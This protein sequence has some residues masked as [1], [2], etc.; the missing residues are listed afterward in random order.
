MEGGV[1]NYAQSDRGNRATGTASGGKEWKKMK[2]AKTWLKYMAAVLI[3]VVTAMP[4]AAYTETV[5]GVEWTF[6][7]EDGEATLTGTSPMT[8]AVAIPGTLGEVPVTAIQSSAFWGREEVTSVSIPASVKL[9]W[10]GVFA[11]CGSLE[12]IEVAADNPEFATENGVLYSKAKVELVSCPRKTAGA[13]AVPAGVTNIIPYAFGYCGELTSVSIGGGVAVIMDYAFYGCGNLTSVSMEDGLKK[14]GPR[15]FAWCTNLMSV[16]IPASVAEIGSG[17]FSGCGKLEGIE[18]AAANGAYASEDGVL[19]DKAKEELCGFPGGKLGAYVLPD[20]VKTIR[21]GA[22]AMCAGL[23]A[24]TLGNGVASIG[25]YAFEGCAGLS[26]LTLPDSVASVGKEAFSGCSGLQT[27]RVPEAWEGTDKLAKAGVPETCAVVYGAEEPGWYVD[28]AVAASGDGTSRATAFKTLAE[29]LS[30]AA[31]GDTVWVAPGTY[32]GSTLDEALWS[33]HGAV[34]GTGKAS[35]TVIQDLSS[36]LKFTTLADVTISDGRSVLMGG[37]EWGKID[38]IIERCI[39]RGCRVENHTDYPVAWAKEIRDS[40]FV[41][42]E[43]VDTATP[44]IQAGLIVSSTLVDNQ[45]PYGLMDGYMDEE[46]DDFVTCMALNCILWNNMATQAGDLG[47]YVNDGPGYWDDAADKWVALGNNLSNCCVNANSMCGWDESGDEYVGGLMDGREGLNVIF[48]DPQFVDAPNGDYRLAE[49]SPCLDAGAP[50]WVVEREKDLERNGRVS[51]AAPDIGCYELSVEPE[52]TKTTPVPVP[53]AWLDENA[54]SILAATGG[55][56]ETAANSTASN[57]VNK[58]WECYLAGLLPETD[59]TFSATFIWKDGEM[60]VTPKP[61][62]GADREYTVE[63]A[64]TLG[65]ESVW[66]KRTAKSRFFRVKVE[67]PKRP[68]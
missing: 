2:S 24:L 12:R 27:L 11:V 59:E 21:D 54:A 9:I 23:T 35:E 49:G 40:L 57:N 52:E 7:V 37:S 15:A 14:I 48:A 62:L 22:F 30:A 1:A 47:N 67:W 17:A 34:R 29:G 16:S 39:V 5:G 36:T 45:A 32:D 60:V 25:D 4:A 56:Y 31:D 61:N 51:G 19:F 13:F 43:C 20:S 44:V 3:A 18:V 50:A 66:G 28:A 58:V 55:N 38:G 8:G 10:A 64:E 26:E 53:H 65:D 41:G 63:G 42:N 33:F 68:E 6:T 46:T